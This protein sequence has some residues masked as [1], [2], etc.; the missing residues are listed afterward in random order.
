LFSLAPYLQRNH[1]DGISCQR[2][3]A[4]A[5]SCGPFQRIVLQ[6][7]LHEPPNKQSQCQNL[8]GGLLP[9]GADAGLTTI[10]AATATGMTS[11]SLRRLILAGYIQ[12]TKHGRDW[13]LAPDAL[14]GLVFGRRPGRQAVTVRS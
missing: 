3:Q 10:A 14:S 7:R 4:T 5:S 9:A 11:Q 1:I 2:F 8:S 13:Q 12:A 6:R